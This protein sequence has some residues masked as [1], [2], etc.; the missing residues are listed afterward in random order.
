LLKTVAYGWRQVALAENAKVI[1]S[2]GEDLYKRAAVFSGHMAKLGKSLGASV[3]TFNSAVGSLERQ[4]L[5]GARKFGELGISTDRQIEVLDP[6]ET[7]VRPTIDPTVGTAA[8]PTD[9]ETSTGSADGDA[10]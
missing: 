10:S 6:I 4:L 5:P 7:L 2:L 9:G 3:D 8:G 1:R